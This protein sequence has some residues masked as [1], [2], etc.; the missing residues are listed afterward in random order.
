MKIP[1]SK[2]TPFRKQ[3]RDHDFA[4]LTLQK[5]WC[6]TTHMTVLSVPR[7]QKLFTRYFLFPEHQHPERHIGFATKSS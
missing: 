6:K 4:L 3:F 1:M 5:K 7:V 2:E